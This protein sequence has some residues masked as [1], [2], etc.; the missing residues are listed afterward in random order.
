MLVTQGC[1]TFTT[2]P[3]LSRYRS[4]GAFVAQGGIKKIIIS[5]QPLP[6]REVSEMWNDAVS[7]GVGH[8]SLM[9]PLMN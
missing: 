8:S 1:C 4:F 2:R 7:D 9:R 3:P 5:Q 6:V